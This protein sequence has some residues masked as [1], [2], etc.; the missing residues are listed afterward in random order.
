MQA[1]STVTPSMVVEPRIYI[2]GKDYPIPEVPEIPQADRASISSSVDKNDAM[3]AQLPVYS[4]L[5][6]AHGRPSIKKLLNEEISSALGPV[7]V[8]GT[9]L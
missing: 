2:T 3:A 7:S 1:L 6:L 8:D 9:V 5:K 4:A